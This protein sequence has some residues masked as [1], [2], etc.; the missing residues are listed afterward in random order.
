MAELA[1][2]D[3]FTDLA[4]AEDPI[5]YFTELRARS[6]VTREPHHGVMMVTGYD[7]AMQVWSQPDKFS[8]CV[9]VTGPM[10]PIPFEVKGDD[11][12]AEVRKHH[13]LFP[14]ATHFITFDQPEHMAHRTMLTR[15]LTYK[16]LKNNELYM[17]GLAD[18]LIDKFI[19]R[20]K[21]ELVNDYAQTLA[22]L[23]ITDLLGVPEADRDELCDVIGPPPG[24][25]GDPDHKAAPDPLE[26]LD[27]RFTEY[28]A[29]LQRAPR[30]NMMSELANSTFADGSK[31]T[32]D[33][34]VRIATFLFVAGQDTSAKLI[35]SI[36][37]ILGER[38]DLQAQL[39]DDRGKIPE[40]IEEALRFESPT[41]VNFR[42]AT[43]STMVGDV[44]IPAGTVLTLG[45][46]AIN[47]DP[48]HFD[49]PDEF[50]MGRPHVRDHIAFGR[51]PHACPGAP[52]ARLEARVTL[53]RFLD[54][55]ENIR[56]SEAEHGPPGAR[57]Y[58]YES[59]YILNGLNVLHLEFDAR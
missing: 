47:R 48:S 37:K 41:K 19:A 28:M 18:R 54:R 49:Q 7:E 55:L 58:D 29:E 46:G 33:E 8:S 3:F 20:G 31:P 17:I 13:H 40:F 6:P 44:A 27:R 23:V 25:V 42:L 43:T 59:T 15:L 51:G 35:T 36:F 50:Q 22:T 52:L 16:R 4:I 38:P 34:T 11:I 14:W 56:I 24:M 10:P 12:S 26:Y 32:L 1:E 5:P 30:D 57:R 45:L 53:E 2:R 9:S 39:R 21:C